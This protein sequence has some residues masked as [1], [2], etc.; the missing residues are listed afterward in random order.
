[1][2]VTLASRATAARRNPNK[3]F[4][5]FWRGARNL[6]RRG[7]KSVWRRFEKVLDEEMT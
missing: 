5:R 1:M 4:A 2:A 7:F 6:G 3:D